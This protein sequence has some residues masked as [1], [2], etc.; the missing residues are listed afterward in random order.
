M[1]PLARSRVAA[2]IALVAL[3]VAL[4]PGVAAVVVVG[5]VYR[6]VV[7]APFGAHARAHVHALRVHA[8]ARARAASLRLA[9]L[10]LKQKAHRS[11]AR[12]HRCVPADAAPRPSRAPQLAG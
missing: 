2:A 10:A 6:P 11:P 5:R 3:C 4:A 7:A 9:W 8:R 12:F 1:A